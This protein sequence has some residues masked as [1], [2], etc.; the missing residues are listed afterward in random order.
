MIKN[1]FQKIKNIII[2]NW[3]NLSG[4]QSDFQKQR[5]KICKKCPYNIKYM[6]TRVCSICGCIIKSKA[7]VE[8]EKCY[9]NKW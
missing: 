2:G 3:R 6:G 7:S 5:L 1:L 9:I 8:N 4:Y